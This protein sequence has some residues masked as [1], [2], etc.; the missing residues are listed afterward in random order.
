[1]ARSSRWILC[2]GLVVGCTPVPPKPSAAQGV[3]QV[4]AMPLNPEDTLTDIVQVV[5]SDSAT[6]ALDQRGAVLCWGLFTH[7]TFEDSPVPL[8]G[9]PASRPIRAEGPQATRITAYPRGVGMLDAAGSVFAVGRLRPLDAE[10]RI[11]EHLGGHAT[12]R[13]LGASTTAA[14]LCQVEVNGRV[15]CDSGWHGAAA[16]GL[17]LDERAPTCFARG[18][19]LQCAHERESILDALNPECT[20]DLQERSVFRVDLGLPPV[21][22]YDAPDGVCARSESGQLECIRRE[23]ISRGC[24]AM[25]M[26]GFEP[27]KQTHTL[28]RET[29]DGPFSDVALGGERLGHGFGLRPDGVV[30]SLASEEPVPGAEGIVELTAWVGHACGLTGSG[31]VLCWGDNGA[32]ELGRGSV[33]AASE[34]A[35]FVRSAKSTQRA[36]GSGRKRR[37]PRLSRT[38]RPRSDAAVPRLC[39]AATVD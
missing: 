15:A 38:L 19:A 8:F 14:P 34:A 33:G 21:A 13:V 10:R 18:K 22:L 25:R 36:L 35:G 2:G 23:R 3:A 30:V 16:S 32:G 26:P 5:A 4:V 11:F 9:L 7:G 37:P 17:L 24:G 31:R 6:C 39:P 28:I 20:E 1:M 12:L 27:P 29:F